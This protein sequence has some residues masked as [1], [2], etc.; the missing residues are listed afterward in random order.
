[1]PEKPSHGIQTAM[2][3]PTFTEKV[4]ELIRAIPEGCVST[5]GGIARLAGNP[6]AARQVVRILHSSSRKEGLPWHRVVN[7]EGCIALK[8]FQGYDLQK[9]LLENEAVAFDDSGRID[10]DRFLW[11]PAMEEVR[12]HTV[13]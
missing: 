5:Y 2:T 4:I 10:L 8:S 12:K 13:E 1:M 6:R 7:R 11:R 9:Q 3:Q